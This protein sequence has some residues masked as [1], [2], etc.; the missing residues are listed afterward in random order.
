MECFKGLS[1]RERCFRHNWLKGCT[2]L[3]SNRW[4]EMNDLLLPYQIDL[5]IFDQ[6]DNSKLREHIDR[7]GQVFYQRDQ[8]LQAAMVD[9]LLDGSEAT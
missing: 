5:S 9:E 2:L 7:V 1:G 4:I 6:L 3:W 8:Q